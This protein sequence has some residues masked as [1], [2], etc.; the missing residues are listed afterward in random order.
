MI[1]KK[2][3]LE[4]F[5]KHYQYSRSGLSNQYKEIEECRSF[6]NGNYMNYVDTILYGRGSS[7]KAQEVSFNMVKPYINAFVGFFIQNRR[8]AMFH[9]NDLDEKQGK[10][11]TDYLNGYYEYIRENTYAD[12]VETKQD[13]D[14]GIGG[15]GVTD[16]AISLKDGTPTRLPG[17]EILKERVDPLECGWD[18]TADHPNAGG[19]A[20]RAKNYD[21]EY[22]LE[23]FD[24]D[25]EDFEA[26]N[27]TDEIHNYK[28]N[29]YGGIQDKIGF[30]Y[31][32]PNRD[33]LRVYF[34]QW[35]EIEKF[36]R[37]ENPLLQ[38]NDPVL[39]RMLSLALDGV[40]QNEE[41]E[42]FAFDPTAETLTI[43]KDL[44][45][46]VKEIFEAFD[47]SFKP[48]AESRKVFFTAVI[49][50]DKVL[51]KFKSVSQQGYS[52]QFK[53]G[54]KD[55]RNNIYTGLVSS[56]KQPQRYYNKSLTEFMLIIA[57]NSKGGVIAE[58]GAIG[59]IQ[60]FEAKWARHNSVVEVNDITKI[61]PKA[62]PQMNTGYEAVMMASSEAF[63]KVTG[64]NETFF[65]VSSSPNET[66]ILQRQRIK[67]ATT[68]LA[69][70]V[71]TVV[72]YTKRQARLLLSFMRMLM[73]S[74]EGSLFNT[75]DDDGNIIFESVSKKYLAD[76]YSIIISEA[77]ETDAQK[78][79]YANTLIQL[80][81]SKQATG[82]IAGADRI[83]SVAI[84]QLPL[85][86]KDKQAVI[87][88]LEGEGLDPEKQ[89]MQMT[90][91][92][93]KQMMASMQEQL[94]NM[95][96]QLDDK[97]AELTIK[98]KAEKD[99]HQIELEKNDLKRMEIELDKQSNTVDELKVKLE[100]R[101]KSEALDLKRQEINQSK[102]QNEVVI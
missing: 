49:S 47:L 3:L 59:N 32:S 13:F 20:W 54:D 18:S 31:S 21:T 100:S 16:T 34:Y 14:L 52:L 76:E 28:F 83:F 57:S 1:N 8:K 62:A 6:Y 15:V 84:K 97:Q 43:T 38:V 73:E 37:I 24:A 45:K 2:E 7:R 35:Y 99:K 80:G 10:V 55:E 22:A 72:F 68:L 48:V 64:I 25:E 90:I 29:P 93:G 12:Q 96:N 41:D 17:G 11:Q 26:V 23:L 46:Q 33:Q 79:Y 89:Q 36:Y 98:A 61:M 95:K 66:A 44:R 91:E 60:E 101:Y 53:V 5:R 86:E 71:D 50:G 102:V 51:Q 92:Q 88:A 82:D 65:G 30:E 74:D 81:Q 70:Y 4:Q 39:G 85:L 67:Q 42:T 94:K 27:A 63:Q 75:K 58:K 56:M 19:W 87:R 78:D 40:D 77:P 9:A 69:P